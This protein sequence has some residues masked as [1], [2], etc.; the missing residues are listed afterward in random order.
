[1]VVIVIV[2]LLIIVVLATYFGL[3]I[4]QW[5]WDVLLSLWF[6]PN[7]T[8]LI[9]VA[10]LIIRRLL[11]PLYCTTTRMLI[12]GSA[13]PQIASASALCCTKQRESFIIVLQ[14]A[15]GRVG[16]RRCRWG[17]EGAEGWHFLLFVSQ[18]LQ[19]LQWRKPMGF[20]IVTA[21]SGRS[22]N[23]LNVV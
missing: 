7:A 22:A 3:D 23:C 8:E 21:D 14:I 6:S 1:V 15:C 16:R 17:R 19:S 2:I 4:I 5:H 11:E 13:R 9:T 20:C 12:V 10:V 18:V